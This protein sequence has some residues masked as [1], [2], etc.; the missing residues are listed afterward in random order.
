M[1][2]KIYQ[3][4]HGPI[5]YWISDHAANTEREL[6][7]LPG[8]T[9]DHRLF[10]RQIAYFEGKYRL[11]VWDAPGHNVSY[12]FE[13]TFILEDKARWLDAILALEGFDNPVIVGQSMGGYLGQMYA[14]IF[15]GKL[16]GFIS[17]DSAPLKREY[18]TG[19]ELWLLER[20]EPVYRHYPWK[21]LL[22]QGTNGVATSEYG[23]EMMLE[24]MMTY[25]GD[26]KRYAGLAG[27]GYRILAGAVKAKLPYDIKCPALL[28]CGGKD[29]A[30]SCIRYNK[31]W[32]KKSGIPIEWIGG[33]GHNSNTDA[34][35]RINQ[36]I[37][38]FMEG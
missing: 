17:I 18:Y 1:T 21:T 14:Q 4:D 27:H 29:R 34:P 30:G 37:E 11:F 16:R 38:G 19:L 23:R 12:P 26:Q 28:I 15:P 20:M 33:A 6:V 22:R 31:A 24:M 10:D 7:L 25:D 5:H 32:H 35:E 2:E 36:L 9:A 8:L 13:M 3:T